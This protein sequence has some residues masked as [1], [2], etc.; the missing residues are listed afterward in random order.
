[1]LDFVNSLSDGIYTEI[2]ER[3]ILLSGGQ[4]QRLAIARAILKNSPIVILDEATSAL[5]N[6]SEA[7]VHK[8]MESL[9]ENRTVII[10]AHRL[11]TI[12]NA[13]RIILVDDGEIKEQGTHEELLKQNGQYAAMYN[14]QFDGKNVS[15]ILKQTSS[16][17]GDAFEEVPIE[18]L[19]A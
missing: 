12:R 18:T 11:S 9:I 7:M 13:D 16:L 1:M 2:G 3:G 5:D 10:I 14:I 4:R 15:P 6:F 17:T 8:A 19:T